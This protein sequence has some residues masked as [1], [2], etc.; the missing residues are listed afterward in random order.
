MAVCD[1]RLASDLNADMLRTKIIFL[2][3]GLL[4]S[5]EKVRR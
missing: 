2:Q 5:W 4:M 1:S 3:L